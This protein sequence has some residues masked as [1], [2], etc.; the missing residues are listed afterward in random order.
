MTKKAEFLK[1]AKPYI[2]LNLAGALISLAVLFTPI[3]WVVFVI[4]FPF[5]F[6]FAH[7][8]LS[9]FGVIYGIVIIINI[10]AFAA[11]LNNKPNAGLILSFPFGSL[12][13]AVGTMFRR[14]F[15]Y[16]STVRIVFNIHIWFLV[17]C[18]CSVYYL[19]GHVHV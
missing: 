14:D 9:D 12:G 19:G 15:K 2:I 11:V 6:I 3:A 4:M 8:G 5:L 18:F 10:F 7:I 17:W 13:S 16:A 1:K